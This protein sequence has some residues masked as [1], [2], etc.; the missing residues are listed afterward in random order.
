MTQR[1]AV[2]AAIR[3]QSPFPVPYCVSFTHRMLEK[4]IAYTGNPYYE[5]TLNNAINSAYLI[6]PET[7]TGLGFFT[8]EFGVVWNRRGL[9]NDIGNV[10]A[11]LIK[12]YA[13]LD[14]YQFP[15]VDEAYIRARMQALMDTAGDRFRVAAIGFSLF[16]RAWTLRGM[17]DLL[18]DMVV[19]PG[20]VHDLLGRITERNLCI[21]RIALQ[22]DIDCFHFGDD[23]GQQKELI[24]GPHHW[25]RF[26]KPC[27]EKMYSAV[28]NAGKFV[29]Q[30]S[31]GDI[32][33]V[34]DDLY[35]MG[36][37][38][39]QTFQPEIYG[40]DYANKLRNR[41]A[42]WG[43]ISTQQDLPAKPPA[44]VRRI[45][46]ELLDAFPYGG[47]VAAPTHDIPGDVPPENV[48]AMMDVL[49][50]QQRKS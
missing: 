43:G 38:M 22:Y 11:F 10:H 24:M 9:D 49:N 3:F 19:E 14:R 5:A 30:H 25:R 39:Y 13:S 6:K 48:L 12:D 45:T 37:S 1:E 7:E 26:I 44:Q 47:L 36:L 31:C 32:R 15:P 18:S 27:L 35:D 28:R 17:E 2:T 29:S 21:I 50:N 8:D 23:W 33:S 20:F 46:Q 16:E 34:M 42:V 41:I 40:L 4:M